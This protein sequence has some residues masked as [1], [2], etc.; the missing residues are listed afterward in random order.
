MDLTGKFPIPAGARI[1]LA[2]FGLGAVLFAFLRLLFLLTHLSL[3]DGSFFPDAII[4]FW[5]GFRFDA[6]ILS[7][8]ILPLFL[9]SLLPFIRFKLKTIRRI[10][11]IVLTVIFGPIILLSIADLK[12][13]DSFGS[14]LNYWAVEYIEFPEMF[15]YSVVTTGGFWVLIIF[16][17]VLTILFYYIIKSIFDRFGTIDTKVG[18]VRAVI[19]YLLITILLIFGI[20]G[21]TGIKP[22]DW[23]EA[24]FSD[25]NFINQLSLNSIY[26]LSHSLYEEFQNGRKLFENTDSRFSFYDI[27]SAY[28][29]VAE[30]LNIEDKITGD[31]Y[32]LSYRLD[33]TRRFDFLPNVILILMESWSVELIG[34][35][36]SKYNVSPNFDSLCADGILF[37]NFYA[38]GIRTNRGL[39]ATLCSFPSLPGRSI[40][41]RYSASYPFRPLPDILN[42]FGYSTNYAYGGDIQFDNM[43]GF[44]KTA[45]YNSF[46]DESDFDNSGQISRW[47][48]P[49]HTLFDK[50]ADEIKGF[51]RPFHLAALTLSFHDPYLIPDEKFKIYDKSIKNHKILNC[52]YYSDW[53]IGRFMEKIR[54]L[55]VFDSTIFIFTADHVAHQSPRYPLSPEKFHIPLLLYSPKLLGDSARVISTTGSQVDIIPTIAGL[56]GLETEI[57]GWGRD[58]FSLEPDDSG[59]AV[60]VASDKLGLIEGSS[61]F[62][63]RIDLTK[64]LYDLNERRY[65]ENDLMEQFPEK[66][67]RMERRLNSYIQ[68]ADY[69][70]R[71]RPEINQQPGISP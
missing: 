11:T 7:I 55:P 38:N 69:L 23:G 67:E 48:I 59:F 66:A 26:T 20:R 37:D 43:K 9:L 60:I 25:N 17:F 16:W 4:S 8:I 57:Y 68:L 24:Y 56:L 62:F 32:D 65:L 6:I 31:N 71:G 64:K 18:R 29:N 51:K 58:L 22:L 14:R 63:H 39:A 54:R 5:I 70:S 13:Y 28:Q 30:M 44:L 42:E 10:Y 33:S 50:L 52:F 12:F 46:Y 3:A 35:L 45:G 21:R 61:F 1:W 40:M 49:D 34:A 19:I 47:G 15:L 41:K 36:G 2:V 53:A 27:D